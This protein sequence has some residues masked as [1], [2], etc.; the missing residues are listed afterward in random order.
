MNFFDK[1]DYFSDQDPAGGFVTYL[2]QSWSV[3]EWGN[4]TFATASSARLEVMQNDPWVSDETGRMSVRVES[5][6]QYNYSLFVFDIIH[7]PYGCGIWWANTSGA[8]S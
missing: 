5:K 6:E 2:N 4:L 1:F 8:P 3:S 7:A